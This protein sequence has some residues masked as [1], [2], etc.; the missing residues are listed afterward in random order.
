MFDL[1]AQIRV[2]ADHLRRHSTMGES[3]VEELEAHLRDEIDGLVGAGLSPDEAFL[4]AVKRVGDVDSVSREFAKVNTERLWKQLLLGREDVESSGSFRREL[5]VVVVLSLIAGTLAKVPEIFGMNVVADTL[6]YIENLSLFVFP[7]VVVYFLWARDMRDARAWGLIVPFALAA[8]A[9]NLY[10]S[11]PPHDTPVLIGIHLPI[12]LW[13]FV[14]IAYTGGRWSDPDRRMDFVRFSGEAF[15]YGVLLVCGGFVL[16]GLTVMAFASIAVD[17]TAF[18]REWLGLYGLAAIPIVAASLV[19]A[20]R[21]VIEN[22]APVLARIFTP[23]FFALTALFLAAMLIQGKSPMMDRQYLIGFDIMLAV[24]LGLVLYVV[25]ARDPADGP[26]RFDMVT[27]G[28]VVS[29][30]LIDLVALWAIVSR[31]TSFG[32]TPNRVAALG[33]NVLLFGNLAGLAVLYARMFL[34]KQDFRP[35]VRWQT[36]YLPLYAYWAGIVAFG[37]PPL[38]GFR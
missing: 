1:E 26:G 8:L 19:E 20:K 23:L 18:C 28:L 38:F 32:F 12:L 24:V 29:T 36:R 9:V 34:K 27:F 30:L 37:F 10:P 7:L 17:A 11:Q 4:I 21:G 2:W 33:E 35:L 3:D 14:G 15:I 16:V 13:L 6:V 31:I 22:L 25:S 5:L